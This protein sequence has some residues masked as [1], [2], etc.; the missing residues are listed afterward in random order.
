MSDSKG[1][2]AWVCSMVIAVMLACA[3][4]A[5]QES[6]DSR[7]PVA[8]IPASHF[9]SPEAA[10]ELMELRQQPPEPDFGG[11]VDALRRFHEQRTDKILI[12]M[13]QLYPVSI[14]S[15]TLGGV[16]TDVVVPQGG[17]A[18]GKQR[19]VLISLH[20]GGFLWGAGSEALVEAVPIA[21]TGQVKVVSIDY[22]MA[23]EHAFPAASADVAAVYRALL[24]TYHPNDI[25]IYGC[26]AGGVLAAQAVAWFASHGLPPPGAIASLC[27]TGAELDGDS[28]YLAPLFAGQPAIPPGGKP[29]QLAGLP[30]FKGIDPHDPLVFPM[31]SPK[32]LAKFPPTLLLAGSRDFAASS[33]TTMQRRLWES[34]VDAE[35]F[36][37][38]GLGHAFMMDP[39]L[40]ESR[41][42][43]SI[44]VRFFDRHLG[45]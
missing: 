22:R 6:A 33:M 24:N 41:E 4:A 11:D 5:A 42:T 40:P 35:L 12:K 7:F 25:G 36:V 2:P 16:R 37:F 14:H 27:G 10:R 29:L 26:S 1:L 23:P 30:Y 43:Y 20:S 28:A 17:V 45:R 21:A 34:G 19:R 32:L 8:D 31:A 15:E 39:A 3:P 38:D 13:R 18:S 44:L 9:A